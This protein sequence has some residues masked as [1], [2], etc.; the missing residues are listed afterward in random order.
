MQKQTNK[1]FQRLNRLIILFIPV[2]GLIFSSCENGDVTYPESFVGFWKAE[3]VSQHFW[4]DENIDSLTGFGQV[5]R[6]NNFGFIEWDHI[7]VS[8]TVQDSEV[9]LTLSYSGNTSQFIGNV[10]SYDKLSGI[11]IAEGDTFQ[12][13][14]NKRS[15]E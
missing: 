9:S 14:Y 8:G 3:E 12:V 4:L 10:I 13:T 2:S 6:V 11:W 5:A 7:D 1:I 15:K